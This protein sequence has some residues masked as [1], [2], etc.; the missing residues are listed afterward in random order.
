MGETEMQKVIQEIGGPFVDCY[1]PVNCNVGHA[2][3]SS[4]G[5]AYLGLGNPE[6]LGNDQSIPLGQKEEIEF[7][8]SLQLF[9]YFKNASPITSNGNRASSNFPPAWLNIA[10][11]NLSFDAFRFGNDFKSFE[12]SQNFSD[13]MDHIGHPVTPEWLDNFLDLKIG[14]AHV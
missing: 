8:H 6:S 12:E 3:I 1:T 4:D 2:Y 7:Y 13:W 11:E 14:R 10:G 5:T 9:P